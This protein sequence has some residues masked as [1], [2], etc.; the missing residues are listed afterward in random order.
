MELITTLPAGCRMAK[1]SD[2]FTQIDEGYRLK[3]PK[4]FYR[5]RGSAYS[6]HRTG[7]HTQE[8]LLLSDIRMGW[9]FIQEL[10]N[11]TE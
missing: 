8:N 5:A 2:L 10:D 4:P 1:V 11:V 3:V 9:I 6:I 7:I